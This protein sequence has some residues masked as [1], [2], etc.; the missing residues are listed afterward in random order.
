VTLAYEVGVSSLAPA[1]ATAYATFW[2]P[3]GTGM[4]K[5]RE[6]GYSNSSA[7]TTLPQLQ[8]IRATAR[9]TQTTTVTPT[10]AANPQDTGYSAPASVIDTAWSVQPTLVA[11][12]LRM[13]DV[14]G[15]VGS[16]TIWTWSQDGEL[17]VAANAGVVIQNAS[18][19]TTAIIRIY[20]V[21]SE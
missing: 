2:T 1:A 18:G 15:T 6:I 5:I 7:S 10:A 4:A 3:S 16:G 13:T 9:G 14:A 19:G 8:L 20:F 21:W 11:I 12:P 17:D